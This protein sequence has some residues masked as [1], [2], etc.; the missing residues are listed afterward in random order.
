M[1]LQNTPVSLLVRIQLAKRTTIN[2]WKDL[3]LGFS[4]SSPHDVYLLTFL[5]RLSRRCNFFLK[6]IYN[7]HI[8][9][10][11]AS[12]LL[13]SFSNC[14]E[15]ISSWLNVSITSETEQKQTLLLSNWKLNSM[16]CCTLL[17]W[18]VFPS[19]GCANEINYYCDTGLS[20]I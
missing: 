19:W 16:N 7:W 8:I 15:T 14:P 20:L 17:V 5:S 9:T 13:S 3:L 12:R 11:T 10:I 6:R 1:Q 4:S 2:Y 18:I